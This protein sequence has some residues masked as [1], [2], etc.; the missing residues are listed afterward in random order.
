MKK[1]FMILSIVS[2]LFMTGCTNTNVD[3]VLNTI[4]NG[5][6]TGLNS[7]SDFLA[8]L[9]TKPTQLFVK[10]PTSKYFE[11]DAY[12]IVLTYM[13]GKGIEVGIKGNIHNKTNS[14]LLFVVDFPIYDLSGNI[15]DKGY[16]K[17]IIYSGQITDLYG[18]YTQYSLGKDLRV[19]GEQVRTRVY[20]NGKLIANTHPQAQARTTAK[21][22]VAPKPAET[23]QPVVENSTSPKPRQT[24]Q[25]ISK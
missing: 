21:K 6:E 8:K 12:K 1:I 2:S 17:D 19:N 10:T 11:L 16:V 24:R 14:Q 25:S 4:S 18:H 3:N 23:K 22:K 7:V 5:I 15:V 9:D 20:L 13:D